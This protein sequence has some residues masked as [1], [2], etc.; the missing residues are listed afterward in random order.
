MD[1]AESIGQAAVFMVVA[2]AA[3]KGAWDARKARKYSAYGASEAAQAR[4][5]TT[6]VGNGWTGE[7][8]TKLDRLEKLMTDHLAAHADS[9]LRR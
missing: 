3:A 2:L 9:D 5:N 6:I 8:D 1:S 4:A 7:I